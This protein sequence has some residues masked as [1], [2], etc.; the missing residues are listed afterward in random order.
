M[1]SLAAVARQKEREFAGRKIQPCT[2]IDAVRLFLRTDWDALNA[3]CVDKASAKHT[4]I[5]KGIACHF[6]VVDEARCSRGFCLQFKA[7]CPSCFEHKFRDP[8]GVVFD[9]VNEDYAV[10]SWGAKP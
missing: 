4:L 3:D 10:N 9:I 7:P 2:E 1:A 5:Q 8:N 6:E